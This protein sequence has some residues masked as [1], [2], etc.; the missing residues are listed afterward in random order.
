MSNNTTCSPPDNL[1]TSC[2]FADDGKKS[3]LY[4]HR[5]ILSSSITIAALSPVAVEGNALILVAIWQKTFQR[6]PFHVL[7]S[8]LAFTDLCTGLIAQPFVSATNL[9]YLTSPRVVF[10]QPLLFISIKIIGDATATYSIAITLLITTLMSVERWLH[11]SRRSLVTSRRG[12]LTATVLF[13]LPLPA[14]VFRSMET[15]KPETAQRQ[16]NITIE[17]GMLFCFVTT[18]V[19]YFNVFRIIRHHQHQIHASESSQ[20]FG[21][22]AIN[23]A[24][25]KRSVVTI[26]YLL[27]FYCLCFLPLIV[28]LSVHFQVGDKPK[29]TL[30]LSVSFV[31]LF[32]SSSLSP[33]LYICRM[34]DIRSGIKRL[35]SSNSDADRD[36]SQQ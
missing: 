18:F 2:D 8:L 15:I 13:L 12:R 24:K 36:S 6:T 23:L 4:V 11:M 7:V 5:A 16:L 32:L 33:V 10:D 1:S 31:L 14:V 25:Y 9:V 26:L 17:A 30:A 34:K 28:S 29:M 21:Q 20:N 35:F 22:S 27:A 3:Y 19:A